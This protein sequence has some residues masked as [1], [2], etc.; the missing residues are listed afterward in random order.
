MNAIRSDLTDAA[1][2][3]MVAARDASAVGRFVYAVATTGVYCRPDCPSKRPRRENVTFFATGA[4]A[5]TAGYRACRRCRPDRAGEVEA[6]IA[7]ACRSIEEAERAP[8]L[9]E[10]AQAAG[11]SPRQFH[12]RFKLALGMTPKEYAAAVR[13]RRLRGG[14]RAAGTVTEAMYDSGF[15]SSSRLYEGADGLLG[16]APARYRT[17]G[18]GE[19]IRHAVVKTSLGRLLVAATE[20]GLCMIELG[21]RAEALDARVAE[22]FPKAELVGQ[23][24][25]FADLVARVAALIEQPAAGADLPLDIRGTAFQ[26]RVWR[27][28]AKIAPGK[29]ASYGELATRIGAPG[30]ARAVA[31]ACA[32]NPLAVAIPCHRAVDGD[33][34]LR[35]Y[36]WGLA[37]KRALLAREAATAEG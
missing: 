11:L 4:E 31:R 6:W 5:R 16:M 15:G 3:A 13:A 12:H 9:T 17:G 7:R 34:K 30:S 35:G 22:R 26:Q 18:A 29:T 20:R 33:G 24:A 27:A 2:W 36:R 10:L 1:R 21:D 32:S 37:R 23:D 25:G 19:S 28:L 8:G 14:L